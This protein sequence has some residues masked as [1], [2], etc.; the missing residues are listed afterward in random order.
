MAHMA[1]AAKSSSSK[2]KPRTTKST[3]TRRA[4]AKRTASSRTTTRKKRVAKPIRKAREFRPRDLLRSPKAPIISSAAYSWELASIM[5]ARD[6]QLAGRFERPVRLAESMRTDDALAVAYWNRLAPVRSLAV[7]LEPAKENRAARDIAAEA[8][9]LFGQ[10]GVAVTQETVTTL[11][12]DLANHGVA[13]GYNRWSVRDDGSRIDVQL[14]AWPL[15]FVYWES[16]NRCLMT[17]TDETAIVPIT[18]G[19]GRWVVFGAYEL[20]PWRHAACLLP[21]ALV[22][23]SHAFANRDWARGSASHGNAKVVGELAEGVAL[24]NI[25]ENGEVSISDEA[26][27]FLELLEDIASL[28]APVGIKPSGS[29]VDY[30]INSSRAW[31]VWERLMLSREKAAAR[32]YLGTDGTLGAAGGAPGV[33][34]AELF[35]IATTILQGDIAAIE[36]GIRTGTM[37]PWCAVNHG[38]SALVPRRKYALPDPDQARIREDLIKREDAFTKAIQARK[39]AGFE[40]DQAWVN[41]L[42]KSLGVTPG[43]LAATERAAVELAPTDVARVIDANEARATVGL[44]PKA[45]G[46]VPLS[47]YGVQDAAAAEASGEA[48]GAAVAEG[49]NGAGELEAEPVAVSGIEAA[50][51]HGALLSDLRD[52]RGLNLAVNQHQINELARAYGT[53]APKMEDPDA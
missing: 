38:D 18:H 49:G 51:L 52:Y 10:D 6:E 26:L 34:I 33:D 14:C 12:G 4:P 31:E 47:T 43:K 9:V 48:A 5:G 37:E 20:M 28:D 24:Q 13:V 40:I 41:E 7:E 25:D 45:D 39:S 53:I 1:T 11:N 17:R 2:T 42:A 36:K 35:N 3:S 50:R 32:I 21:A 46:D 22:W 27:Y 15:E 23:A 30:L 16:V 19:D 44:P 8:E 29:K